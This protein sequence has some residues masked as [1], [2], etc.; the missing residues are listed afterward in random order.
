MLTTI[1]GRS[2][3]LS[4]VTEFGTNQKPHNYATSY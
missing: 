4:K 3:V 2:S 1:V